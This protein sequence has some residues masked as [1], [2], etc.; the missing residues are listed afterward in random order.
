M[1]V[2]REFL[3]LFMEAKLDFYK[4]AKLGAIK[5]EDLS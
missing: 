5:S 2:S 4:L 3:D 1:D